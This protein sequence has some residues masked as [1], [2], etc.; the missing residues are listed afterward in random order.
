MQLITNAQV[1][2]LLGTREA[3]D[4]MRR[5]FR[6]YG[7]S[8]QMQERVRIDCG[9]TKL[10]M[11]G[12]ILPGLSAAGAKVYTTINGKFTFAILLFS[13]VD[14]SLLAALEGDAM[15]EFRTAAASAVA[16]DILSRKNA[17]TLGIIG[18]GVQAKA[19]VAAMLLIREFTEVLVAGI[20]RPQEFAARTAEEFGIRCS[21]ATAAEVAARSDILVTATRSATPLF[22][23]NDVKQGAFVAAIGASKADCREIDDRLVRRAA[24]IVVEWKQQARKE[25][26]DLLLCDESCFNWDDVLELADVAAGSVA[27]QR[28]DRDVILYKAIGVGLEDIALAEHV[29]TRIKAQTKS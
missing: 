27:V 9:N 10:S 29:Y 25:A 4:V 8:G 3:I 5:A 20:D 28:D 11:M 16:A 17:R 13:T 21:V 14:G 6:Q 22:N 12:A 2:E 1:S 18:T 15:T 23:G 24:H 26:G 7:E 19:H